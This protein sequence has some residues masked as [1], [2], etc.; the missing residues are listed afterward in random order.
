M[1]NSFTIKP[2][3][4]LQQ[5]PQRGAAR[6]REAVETDLDATRS[7]TATDRDGGHESHDR[8]TPPHDVAV[9]SES[10]AVIN[11]ENDIRAQD[12]HRDHPDR[13]LLRFR[14]YRPAHADSEHPHDE[15]H[16]NI[17]A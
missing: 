8:H 6:K 1:D 12:A 2:R 11:R 16:A 3:P 7:V 4:G 10:R 15:P 9:D 5:F 13:A 17:K 14:A